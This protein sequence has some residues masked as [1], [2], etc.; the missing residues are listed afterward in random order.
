MQTELAVFPVLR[1]GW[2]KDPAGTAQNLLTKWS[3]CWPG[4]SLLRFAAA[5]TSSRPSST[6]SSKGSDPPPPTTWSSTSC[7]TATE[8]RC[9][10]RPRTRALC[11]APGCPCTR[12]PPGSR[13][14]ACA[15]LSRGLPQRAV[16]PLRFSD[17]P[18][19]LFDELSL[20][21]ASWRESDR[22][23]RIPDDTVPPQFV[24][25]GRGLA[26]AGGVRPHRQGNRQAR[27]AKI[28]AA[29]ASVRKRIRWPRGVSVAR[30]GESRP[31]GRGW[32]RE[33]SR[34]SRPSDSA[35]SCLSSTPPS[36]R[37]WTTCK[38]RKQAA[39]G[40]RVRPA[41]LHTRQACGPL[42]PLQEH[43]AAQQA[44]DDAC[45]RC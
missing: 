3:G 16:G 26:A 11:R 41:A 9:F 28:T 1:R 39:G 23:C 25:H 37:N 45:V 17:F 42:Q 40:Q 19:L 15:A 6:H 5:R 7:A 38:R 33:R 32:N 2:D 21:A 8:S 24:D 13:E 14:Q 34:G 10:L 31:A 30:C 22:R 36:G 44:L 12:G 29:A 4:A 43:R 35:V 18:A 27:S 20:T